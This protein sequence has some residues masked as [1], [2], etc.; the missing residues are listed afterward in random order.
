MDLIIVIKTE[1][2]CRGDEK[3]LCLNSILH[4]NLIF[5]YFP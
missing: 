4:Y 2:F 5:N 3:L 1:T